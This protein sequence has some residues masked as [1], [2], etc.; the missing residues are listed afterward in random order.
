[1]IGKTVVDGGPFLLVVNVRRLTF[2]VL[3]ASIA[4]AWIFRNADFV[5]LCVE[6]R[7]F[8]FVLEFDNWV[9]DVPAVL[10]E[11]ADSGGKIKGVANV[12]ER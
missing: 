11:G 7:A 9:T 1:L 10:F 12:S 3:V 2:V 6:T 8:E 5:T 4:V